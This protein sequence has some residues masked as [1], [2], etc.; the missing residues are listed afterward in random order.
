[1]KRISAALCL[2]LLL[3]GLANAAFGIFQTALPV[4][5]GPTNMGG[6]S[7]MLERSLFS[8][9]TPNLSYSQWYIPGNASP[10]VSTA[11]Y[12][13]M[14][15][16]TYTKPYDL[17]TMGA[18]GAAIKAANGGKRY[19]W[20]MGEDHPGNWFGGTGLLIGYSNDPQVWPDPSSMRIIFDLQNSINIT[21]KL[22]QSQVNLYAYWL[23]Y[24]VYNPDS[25]GDKFYIYAECQSSGGAARGHQLCLLTTSDFQTV[26]FVG[27]T[28]KALPSPIWVTPSPG[29]QRSP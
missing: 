16:I 4:A 12:Y 8:S 26:T 17:D 29:R 9:N 21:D 20:A 22:G 10:A 24:V 3:S 28:S 14:S 2:L 7:N 19:L 6:G 15:G 18:E 13:L 1:M 27:P 5:S 25:A 23:W 11:S